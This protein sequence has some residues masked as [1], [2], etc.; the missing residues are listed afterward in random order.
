MVPANIKNYIFAFILLWTGYLIFQILLRVFYMLSLTIGFSSCN[1]ISGTVL[2]IGAIYV[3][4]YL[5]SHI[6]VCLCECIDLKM[7]EDTADMCTRWDMLLCTTLIIL[8]VCLH[9]GG[10]PA[11]LLP[12]HVACPGAFAREYVTV[13]NRGMSPSL[14]MKQRVQKIGSRRGCHHCGK[15]AKQYISDHMPPTVLYV[16]KEFPQRLYP[17]CQQ[18]SLFQGGTLCRTTSFS[19]FSQKGVISYSWRFRRWMFWMPYHLLVDFLF[20][21]SGNIQ[22]AKHAEYTVGF[23]VW[24]I[25]SGWNY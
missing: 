16:D 5:T 13:D 11:Q 7:F 8:L 19:Y 23:S 15:F 17:Q 9:S 18:C 6:F 2:G 14:S 20:D 21:A 25:I 3:S 24:K 12:S 1:R 10:I 22:R 4:N